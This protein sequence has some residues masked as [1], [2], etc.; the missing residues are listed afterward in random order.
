MLQKDDYLWKGVLE[1]AFD[2]FLR[3]MH[4]EADE[5]FDFGKEFVFL[6]KELQDMF[7]ADEDMFSPKYVDKLAKVYLKD[8]SERWILIHVEVQGRYQK[9]FPLRMYTYHH[10]IWG[11]YG[12]PISAYAILTD[13]D[14]QGEINVFEFDC[15]TTSLTYKYKVYNILNQDKETLLANKNPFA[16]VVLT[17][18]V[19]MEGKKIMDPQQRDEYLYS[20][21][22]LLMRNLF[23]Q[24]ISKQKIRGIMTFISFYVRFENKDL[25][26]NFD[27]QLDELKGRRNIMGIEEL[28]LDRAE[29]IGMKKGIE[30]NKH[31]TII[32]L[33]NKGMDDDFISDVTETDI[34]FIKKIR[35]TPKG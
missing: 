30:K 5:I 33:I 29:K 28:I 25:N 22:L 14:Y 19:V 3:M 7:P 12:H 27:K 23:A 17:A 13:P 9:D 24:K 4:P 34:D 32:R 18:R 16:V 26:H 1:E 20:Q 31:L 11:K 2:D 10:R 6:D 35:N 8:G 21:K 15:L